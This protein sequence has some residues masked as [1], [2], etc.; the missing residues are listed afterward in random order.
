MSAE[1]F[2]EGFSKGLEAWSLQNMVDSGVVFSFIA[3]GM[4]ACRAYLDSYKRR[5]TLRISSELWDMF[6]DLGT[7]LFLFGAALIG[8][9]TCNPDIMVDVKIALPWLPLASLLMGIALILRSFHG[10][11]KTQSKIWWAALVLIAV[12]CLFNW[13]GFTFV[14]EGATDEY[15]PSGQP[16]LWQALHHMRSDMNREL[17]LTTFHWLSPAFALL[18]AWALATG[19]VRTIASK[20]E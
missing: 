7:D 6:I 14:M 11:H 2:A 1:L 20:K 18:F 19:L 13:F 4:M 15:F 10:G 12:A 3:L 17:S 5:M 8:L 9:L 16:P